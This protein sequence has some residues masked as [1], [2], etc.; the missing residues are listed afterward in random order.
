MKK[1]DLDKIIDEAFERQQ[2]A[3]VKLTP[4][5]LREM[6]E[7]V[8]TE[9]PDPAAIEALLGWAQK[10]KLEVQERKKGVLVVRVPPEEVGGKLR[11]ARGGVVDQMIRDLASQGF[12]H[13]PNRGGTHG[14]FVK[15]GVRGESSQL[16]VLVKSTVAMGGG[17][18]AQ[19]GMEA[20]E[21]LVALI[22]EKY[23]SLG[24]TATS[25]G[26]G[27][28][29]DLT[30]SK[31]GSDPMTIEVK[32]ALGADF[33][34][35]RI[36]YDTTSG[37]W[38]PS[39]TS[40]FLKNQALFQDIFDTSVAPHMNN[41]AAFTKEEL[42]LPNLGMASGLVKTLKPMDGTGDLKMALQRRWFGGKTDFKVAFD[43][44]KISKYYANKGDRYMQI[45]KGKGLYGLTPEDAA[46]IG[47]PFFGDV[48]LVGVVR[49][50]IKPHGS[51]NGNHSF[52][53]AI[54][55]TGRLQPSSLDLMNEGDLDKIIQRYL[56]S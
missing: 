19:Q 51:Y 24:V 35:F 33:G 47:V 28:G 3:E 16:V 8:I 26:A 34:Q 27:H 36:V 14:R 29:S 52:T 20:E 48:G 18:A 10:N 46:D 15:L 53:V 39:Q 42:R 30:I 31:E 6:I 25:A 50:R 56:Q 41:K 7:T 32:T 44:D 49:I 17:A 2:V 4:A 23:G 55:L 9:A 40:G 54:K 43:F 12:V 22:N 13:D 11:D 1:R 45:G 37:E 38:A 5:F 21:K